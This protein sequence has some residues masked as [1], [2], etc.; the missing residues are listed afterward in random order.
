[1]KKI[2]A[3]ILLFLAAL[4]QASAAKRFVD[5]NIMPNTVS[6]TYA[7]LQAAWYSAA[8]GDTLLL[9]P[10]TYNIGTL[11]IDRGVSIQPDTLYG[12]V[13]LTGNFSINNN[14]SKIS[15]M[16]LNITGSL[17][18]G[19]GSDLLIL[20]CSIN[21][22]SVYGAIDKKANIIDSKINSNV[23]LQTI[24]CGIFQSN[25]AGDITMNHGKVIASKCNNLTCEWAQQMND[26]SDKNLFIADTITGYFDYKGQDRIAIIAN[27]LINELRMV[28]WNYTVSRE[29]LIWNN[30]FYNESKFSFAIKNVPAYN[31]DFSNNVFSNINIPSTLQW[32]SCYCSGVPNTNVSDYLFFGSYNL[33][34]I[35]Y[36]GQCAGYYMPPC[37]YSLTLLWSNNSIANWSYVNQISSIPGVFKWTYNGSAI[38]NTNGSGSFPI[39]NIA[40]TTNIVD[41]GN[42]DPKYMDIDMTVNDRGRLGGPYSILNYNSTLNPSN[43]RAYIYDI[44][45][46]EVISSPTQP[47]Q[48]KASGYHRN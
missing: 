9:R 20:G 35:N 43:G 6:N 30:E 19:I 3:F 38:G 28:S 22:V 21:S 17:S 48:I 15:L 7:T 14:L 45:L 39:T 31:L 32:I 5:P 26:T 36:S 29:N 37:N 25:I 34:S 44:E 11:T 1:M 33:S 27:N 23:S 12:S 47:I 2:I 4:Q 8:N 13:T 42:P 10:G 46:P 41:A 16:N 24:D 18:G 40:G